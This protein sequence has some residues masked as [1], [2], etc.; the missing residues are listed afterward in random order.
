MP[1]LMPLVASMLRLQ[2]SALRETNLGRINLQKHVEVVPQTRVRRLV[3]SQIQAAM[4]IRRGVCRPLDNILGC[5]DARIRRQ[6][7]HIA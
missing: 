7:L 3:V 5:K 1:A 2:I 6:E 4:L